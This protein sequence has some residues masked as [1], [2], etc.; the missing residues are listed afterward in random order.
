MS[1][2]DIPA[3]R[4]EQPFGELDFQ[5]PSGG[6]GLLSN[7]DELEC[8]RLLRGGDLLF[9]IIYCFFMCYCFGSYNNALVVRCSSF[10]CVAVTLLLGLAAILL[11]AAGLLKMSA[12]A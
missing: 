2:A 8:C 12:G 11:F 4:E 6:G 3:S 7:D 9:T 1:P 10:S 5:R